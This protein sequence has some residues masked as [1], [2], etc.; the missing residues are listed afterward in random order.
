MERCSSIFSGV[1]VQFLLKIDYSK[2]DSIT[3]DN[4]GLEKN[5][6][7]NSVFQEKFI[8]TPILS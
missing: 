1:F 2:G 8:N 4:L 3:F 6:E 7:K 5:T